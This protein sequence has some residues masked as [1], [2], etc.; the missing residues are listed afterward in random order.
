MARQTVEEWIVEETDSTM[1]RKMAQTSVVEARFTGKPMNSDAKRFPRSGGMSSGVVTKGGAYGEDVATNDTV[2]IEAV[3]FG[4]VRRF[5]EEDI[6]DSFVNLLDES[7]TSWADSH[8]I[9]FDN[10]CLATT[11]AANGTTVPF[12]SI[13]RALSVANAATAYTANANIIATAA[14]VAVTYDNLAAL[15]GKVE[16]GRYWNKARGIIIADTSFLSAFRLIKDANGTPIFTANP[17]SDD[18]DTLFGYPLVWSNGA[19]LSATASDT[20]TG[21]PIL[22]AINPDYAFRGDRSPIE[23]VVIDGKDGAAALTDETLL[24]IRTRK[25]FTLAHEKAAAILVATPAV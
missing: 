14:G 9:L 1:V 4:R 20:P 15:L 24:K 5:A 6:D 22:V 10:A 23:T 12:M 13:Y 8:A 18:P 19:R 16:T 25:G 21:A 2:L 3:K 17:R 7:K 11:G